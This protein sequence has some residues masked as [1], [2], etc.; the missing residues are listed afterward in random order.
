[1][2]NGLMEF[3]INETPN[4]NPCL[5]YDKATGTEMKITKYLALWKMH[6]K[7]CLESIS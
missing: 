7:K 3:V 4:F 2:G 6:T 5:M 1:M